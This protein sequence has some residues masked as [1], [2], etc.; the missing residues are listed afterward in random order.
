LLSQPHSRRKEFGV[1][2]HLDGTLCQCHHHAG[3]H[4]CGNDVEAGIDCVCFGGKEWADGRRGRCVFDPSHAWEFE[5]RR[6]RNTSNTATCPHIPYLE[7][8]L[9]HELAGMANASGQRLANGL[10]KSML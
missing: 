8:D 4:T 6:K 1:T 9:W 3:L 2:T 5:L 10:R 7:G